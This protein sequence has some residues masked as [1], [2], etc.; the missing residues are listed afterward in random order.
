MFRKGYGG[1]GAIYRMCLVG[2]HSR[3]VFAV[4]SAS[5]VDLSLL[6]PVNSSCF[7][8]IISTSRRL[9]DII[10]ASRRLSE[11]ISISLSASRVSGIPNTTVTRTNKRR[12]DPAVPIKYKSIKQISDGC[13]R[14]KEAER[15]SD[16]SASKMLCHSGGLSVQSLITPLRLR[17]PPI[18]ALNQSLQ[19]KSLN[20]GLRNAD[21][22]DQPDHGQNLYQRGIPQPHDLLLRRAARPQPRR[23][24]W[25]AKDSFAG[26]GVRPRL[27]GR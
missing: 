27:Y 11:I 13:S 22:R 1:S 21:K 8:D 17:S 24:R 10:L 7:S 3:K 26:D 20:N 2:V 18:K 16:R 19:S 6:R 14:M 12:N 4:E 25:G 15:S 5:S 23:R 9:S